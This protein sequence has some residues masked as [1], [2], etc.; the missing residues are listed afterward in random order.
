MLDEGYNPVVIRT[1]CPQPKLMH[2]GYDCRVFYMDAEEFK[3]QY[4]VEKDGVV[5]PR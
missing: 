3:S 5:V 4:K 2:K 1:Y